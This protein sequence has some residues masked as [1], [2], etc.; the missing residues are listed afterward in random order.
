M[1]VRHSVTHLV[2][3]AAYL[4]QGTLYGFASF[5]LIPTLAQQGVS[6]SAQTGVVALAGVP[7]VLKLA[8]APLLDRFGRAGAGP[9]RA[10]MAAMVVIAVVLLAMAQVDRPAS[11]IGTLASLWLLLNVALSLQDVATDAL[12]LDVIEPARRGVAN[13]MML[14]SHHLGMDL[15][16]GVGLGMLLASRGLSAALITAGVAVGVLALAPG[17]LERSTSG[18]SHRRNL[19]L[20][21]LGDL[22]RRPRTW[23]TFTVAALVLMADVGTSAVVGEFLVGRLHWSVERISTQLP[24]VVGAANVAAFG[25]AAVWVDKLGHDKAAALGSLGLGVIWI[26]F[27]LIEPLWDQDAVL[28]SMIATQAIATALL[29]V[30]LHAA[31]MDRT[32]PAFRATHFAVL[33]ALLNVPRVLAPP[34]AAAVVESG[35]WPLSFGCAGGY[36]V[37]MALA[38]ALW[39]RATRASEPHG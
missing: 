2:L 32:E 34:L 12:A 39:S 30:G 24:W 33:M 22:L 29:Y 9:R 36:Q 38:L 6:L 10:L 18:A 15:V 4:T 16:G 25:W 13:G 19:E 1:S 5:I 7:W 21:R 14:G 37:V 8:W 11:R 28:F 31:L 3:S 17:L 27:A 26:G 35:G 20:S 23:G